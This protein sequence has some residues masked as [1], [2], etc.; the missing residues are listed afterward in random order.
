[1]IAPPFDRDRDR[2]GKKP[3]LRAVAVSVNDRSKALARPLLVVGLLVGA[4]AACERKPSTDAVEARPAPVAPSTS[5]EGAG[6]ADAAAAVATVEVPEVRIRPN[7]D[8]TVHVKW[9]TP[10]GT[11]VNDEAPFR[12]RWNTSDG[13]VEAP[14]DV[15]STGNA[16]KEGFSVTV[17]P[18]AG[19][20]NAT[21]AGEINIVVCDSQSHSVC[22]PVRRSVELGFIAAKDA[23]AETTVGIPLPSAK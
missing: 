15:K 13:L 6:A 2:Q 19:A 1:V 21:L 22:V 8:T 5:A 3:V 10:Q 14:N 4:L 11:E 12:V 20:P 9:V 17:Q 16:V 23:V 7:A 18:M